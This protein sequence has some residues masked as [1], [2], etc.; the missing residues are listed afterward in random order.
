MKWTW[1]LP[2]PQETDNLWKRRMKLTWTVPAPDKT[3]LS[4][5]PDVIDV[6]CEP[7]TDWVSLSPAYNWCSVYPPQTKRFLPAP[8][9]TDEFCR[10]RMKLTW[11]SVKIGAILPSA[12]LVEMPERIWAQ[13]VDDLGKDFGDEFGLSV[14]R[15]REGV[16]RQWSLG[17]EKEESGVTHSVRKRQKEKVIFSNRVRRLICIM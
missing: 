9:I 15:D 12:S 11:V 6:A 2:A 1:S 7:R 3:Y 17:R 4:P 13:L 8:D 16:R 14:A 5:N 10:A